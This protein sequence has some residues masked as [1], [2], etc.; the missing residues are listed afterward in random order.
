MDNVDLLRNKTLSD[1]S[2]EALWFI[3]HSLVAVTVLAL[4]VAAIALG[5]PDPDSIP[6]K[7][8]GTALALLIPSIAGFLIV[9]QQQNRIAAFVWISGLLVFSVVCVFVLDLPTGNGL[10]EK[11]GAIEKLWRTFFDIAHGSGLMSGDGLL[12]GTWIPLSMIGYAVGAKCA[13]D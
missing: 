12:F 3:L 6:P 7:L 1:L 8:I 10:C 11:C 13:L 5:R 2:R 9:R 4:V